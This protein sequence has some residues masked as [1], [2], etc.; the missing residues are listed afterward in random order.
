MVSSYREYSEKYKNDK[1]KLIDGYEEVPYKKSKKNRKK[2]KRSNHKHEYIPALYYKKNEVFYGSHCKICG[3]IQ[4]FC[5]FF[6][7]VENKIKRF[8]KQY[9][10]YVEVELPEDWN[11]F[12][13]NI[14]YL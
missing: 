4:N 6:Y 13:K 8:K 12:S 2:N 9:P 7:D 14:P 3:R 5:F 1:K 11:Y 10:N